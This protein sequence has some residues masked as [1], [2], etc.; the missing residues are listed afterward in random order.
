MNPKKIKVSDNNIKIGKKDRVF[1][2][3]TRWPIYI[4]HTLDIDGIWLRIKNKL[5]VLEYQNILQELSVEEIEKWL[6][7]NPDI[8]FE[9]D[10]FEE[11]LPNYYFF[12]YKNKIYCYTSGKKGVDKVR[13]YARYY[14]NL[15]D[16]L[17]INL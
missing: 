9:T 14:F 17:S 11:M 13:I 1:N 3:T 7:D 5:D 15:E 12:K 6:W 2:Y 10:F 4:L 8:A 16:I